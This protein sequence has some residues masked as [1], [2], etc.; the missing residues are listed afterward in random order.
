MRRWRYGLGLVGVLLV[1]YGGLRLLTRTPGEDLRPLALWLLAAVL[2]HDGLVAPAELGVGWALGRLPPR[3]RR[4]AQ[5]TLIVSGMLL[6]VAAPLIHRE[7]SQPPSKT[8]LVR[9][10]GANLT[11]LL[12]MV[13]SLSALAYLWSALPRRD[14]T[15]RS[16]RAPESGSP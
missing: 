5:A 16:S 12:A 7:G 2:I 1:A 11:V 4:F 3:A 14:H 9:D 13:A 15:D 6:V 8:L 10:Y